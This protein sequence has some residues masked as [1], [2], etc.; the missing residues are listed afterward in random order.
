MPGYF[1]RVSEQVFPG[2]AMQLQHSQPG[3]LPSTIRLDRDYLR[4]IV[5]RLSFPRVFGTP[6]NAKAEELVAEELRKIL[7]SSLVVGKTRNV[8]SGKLDQARILIGAHYDSVPNTPGADDNASAVAV[9]LAVARCL[10]SRSDVA[11]VA[12]NG[13]ECG[14]VGSHEFVEEMFDDMKRLEQVHVL[15]MVG[16]RDLPPTHGY[17]GHPGLRVH[18]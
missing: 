1:W 10:G 9:M 6:E 3:T 18:G 17:P 15:E 7:G 5:R 4:E 16:Y 2:A 8:C 11:Y 13:E 14:L 12:F